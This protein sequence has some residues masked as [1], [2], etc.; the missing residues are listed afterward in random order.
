MGRKAGGGRGGGIDKG[1]WARRG[2]CIQFMAI[3][4]TREKMLHKIA[5]REKKP[6]REEARV[7]EQQGDTGQLA[8]WKPVGGRFHDC[9]HDGRGSEAKPGELEEPLAAKTRPAPVQ[10]SLGGSSKGLVVWF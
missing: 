8:S 10:L 4:R 1:M 3:S 2:T 9:R 5:G 6:R 7:G